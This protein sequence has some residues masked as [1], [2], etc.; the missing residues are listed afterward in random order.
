MGY[1]V[2]AFILVPIG[3]VLCLRQGNPD[4]M[5]LTGVLVIIAAVV[6]FA[7]GTVTALTGKAEESRSGKENLQEF[8]VETGMRSSKAETYRATAG[9]IIQGLESSSLRLKTE[10]MKVTEEADGEWLLRS[11]FVFGRIQEEEGTVTEIE[12]HIPDYREMNRLEKET[13]VAGLIAPT[14]S[15]WKGGRL[16]ETIEGLLA[17]AEQL[18]MNVRYKSEFSRVDGMKIRI[19][20]KAYEPIS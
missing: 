9:Q 11:D 10:P 8:I 2:I 3:L 13:I 5:E 16:E 12:Y 15:S 4:W 1:L 7:V 20:V 6:L 19:E 17:G 18:V 14:N